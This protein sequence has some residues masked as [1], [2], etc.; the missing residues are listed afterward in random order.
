LL[1][2]ASKRG[3]RCPDSD[4]NHNHAQE[5]HTTCLSEVDGQGIMRS[6]LSSVDAVDELLDI[7]P[8]SKQRSCAV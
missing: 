7:T 3:L 8:R 6:Q 4:K 5:M 2:F 1:P